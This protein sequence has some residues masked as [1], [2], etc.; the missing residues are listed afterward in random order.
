MSSDGQLLEAWRSGSSAA[1]KDLVDRHF[2]AVH[3][4][5]VNKVSADADD[6]VQ[7]TFLRCV[8]R[9]DAFR[10]HSSFRTFVFAV[11]RYV[12]YEHYRAQRRC[13]V[14]FGVTSLADLDPSPSQVVSDLE[15]ERTL[16]QALRSIPAEMQL[17]VELYYWE[18]LSTRE[19]ADVFAVARGTIKSRLFAARDALRASCTERGM[20]VGTNSHRTIPGWA[21]DLTELGATS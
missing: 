16:Y 7:T 15:W 21:R 19:L 18:G 8:E 10:G 3:R 9:R 11:A 17:L 14:E 12:L 13:E 2:A 6:L 5:F 4:F 1:G 20:K